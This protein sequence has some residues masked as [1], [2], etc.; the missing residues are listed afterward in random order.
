MRDKSSL[1]QSI[2]IPERIYIYLSARTKTILF[3]FLIHVL[4]YVPTEWKLF[5]KCD[6][7][8]SSKCPSSMGRLCKYISIR[9]RRVWVTVG[10]V[11]AAGNLELVS[12]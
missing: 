4:L 6:K 10:R 3:K 1:E 5:A 11:R 8:S 12:L 2:P 9:Y 7:N